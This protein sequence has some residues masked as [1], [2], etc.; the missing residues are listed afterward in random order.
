MMSR[1]VD[2]VELAFVLRC[3]RVV[4]DVTIVRDAVVVVEEEVEAVAEAAV[5]EVDAIDT[6]MFRKLSRFLYFLP[7]K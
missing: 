6:G 3:H 4:H 1:A 7:R 2:A 5:E